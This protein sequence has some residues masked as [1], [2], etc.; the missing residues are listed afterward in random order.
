MFTKEKNVE[1]VLDEPV[2]KRFK[3]KKGIWRELIDGS[4]LTREEVV[5]QL[6]F[7]LFLAFLA[8]IYIGNRYH[9]EKV[10]RRILGLQ[11]ELKE[12]RA[13]TVTTASELMRYSMPS[14]VTKK[15]KEKGI[16][17]KESLEPPKKIVIRKK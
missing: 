14:E 3:Q 7:I 15:L 8:V 9:A 12:L 1:F 11:G 6:P 17:L 4:L 13:E 16:D 2:K 10:S 5:K